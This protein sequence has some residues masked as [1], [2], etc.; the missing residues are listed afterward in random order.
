[1]LIGGV[2]LLVGLSTVLVLRLAKAL[3]REAE[4]GR[5][6]DEPID[7]GDGLG[8][9]REE[10]LPVLEARV[11]RDEEGRLG[12]MPRGDDAEE[13][14]GGLGVE[15]RVAELLEVED[16]GLG[17]AAESAAVG[18]FGDRALEILEHFGGGRSQDGALGVESRLGERFEDAGLAKPGA[19]DADEVAALLEPTAV[20]ELADNTGLDLGPKG[21]VEV[22]EPLDRGRET[23]A[24]AVAVETTVFTGLGLDA[25]DGQREVGVGATGLLRLGEELGELLAEREEVELLGQRVELG[26][27]LLRDVAVAHHG[28]SS[29]SSSSGSSSA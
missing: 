25:E 13:V 24:L 2:D 29:S 18:A 28:R 14:V 27:G 20:E 7:G 6:V 22:L 8:L 9:A 1:M 15:G 11:G 26:L 23:R 17:V 21:E 19:P 4:D 16:G 3:T 12:L 10:R 5:A